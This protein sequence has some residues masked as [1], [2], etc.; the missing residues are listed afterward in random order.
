MYTI[1]RGIIVG[2]SVTCAASIAITCIVTIATVR[3]NTQMH[4]FVVDILYNIA[5]V[6]PLYKSRVML[7]FPLSVV[8]SITTRTTSP[9]RPRVPHAG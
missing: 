6:R 8:S 9:H 7:V 3:A 4:V 1:E 2:S 5:I